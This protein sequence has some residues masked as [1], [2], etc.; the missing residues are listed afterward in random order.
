MSDNARFHNK[1]HRKNHHSLPTPGYP[2][3]GTDPIASQ[4][5]PFYGDF[6]LNGNL[7][8]AGA[9]NTT[10]S[11]LSNISI[12]TPT[13]SSSVIFSPTN[14]LIVQLSGT[15]FA[16]P[17]TPIGNV[18]STYT[19]PVVPTGLTSNIIT[20]LGKTYIVGPLSGND[21]N[22]WN[23]VWTVVS[24]GSANWNGNYT[25]V[26]SNSANWT[27]AYITTTAY[28]AISGSF[29][30]G[31]TVYTYINSTSALNNPTYNAATYAQL[32]AQAF[33]VIAGT[34]AIRPIGGNNIAL[35]TLS[36]I[37]GGCSNQVLSAG[38]SVIGGYCNI[39]SGQYSNVAG[40]QNNISCGFISTVVGG[41]L[42]TSSG[43]Y[44]TVA[45]GKSNCALNYAAVVGGGFG[46]VACNNGTFIG[47][48]IN[49]TAS[50]IYSS[51]GGGSG[52]A[53][54]SSYSSVIGGSF[55]TALNVYS[56][57]AGGICN[58]VSG[59][60]S[61]VNGG[62]SNTVSGIYSNVSNGAKNN[63]TGNFS[64]VVGGTYNTASGCYG[65][66][67]GG[68]CN[69]LVGNSSF[70]LGSN[71]TALSANTVYVNNFCSLGAACNLGGTYSNYLCVSTGVGGS[72]IPN[73]VSQFFA[74]ANS[75]SQ[76]NNQNCNSGSNAS[77]DY[78][79]TADN[80]SDATYYIDMGINSS[81][82]TNTA[83]NIVSAND[84]YLYT[85]GGR[86]A[87]GT[88]SSC[89]LIFHTGGTS[90][91][92][93]R[94]RITP[95]GFVGIGTSAPVATLTVIGGISATGAICGNNNIYSFSNASCAIIPVNGNN[96][97]I[98][99]YALISN[100]VC[101]T[102]NN[103]YTT[104]VNGLSNIGYAG[105][106]IGSG[107]LNTSSGTYSTI[108][109]GA[110][111]RA[112]GNYSA[113]GG[114]SLNCATYNYDSVAGGNCNVA[115]G[116]N[117]HVGGGLC[118]YAY[119]PGSTVVGG[120]CNT[121]SGLYSSIGG[122]CNN[123][124][125]SY[126]SGSN[127][128][129]GSFNVINSPCSII[130]GGSNNCTCQPYTFILGSSLSATQANYTYVNNISST[131]IVATS[132]IYIGNSTAASVSVTGLTSK[133]PIYNATGTLIGYVPI[134]TSIT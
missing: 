126:A 20:Y 63:V 14:T 91:G 39:A 8:V 56:S 37:A 40:G 92:Y 84:G 41:W 129:G 109:G 60:Y 103:T 123:T 76:I 44:S 111:N 101:N 65:A 49:N 66:I 71:I 87:I 120:Y 94:M 133:F 77:T 125:V 80:G 22:T 62:W 89:D 98:G 27:T 26:S 95:Q 73:A 85:Q 50:G 23:S 15:Q 53:A 10:F 115:S 16:I 64:T 132:A 48:G 61:S 81:G 107:C 105:A 24:A 114:G 127:I 43:N 99:T 21:A 31:N 28:A 69:T 134:Y 96:Q 36:N 51:I 72:V 118:N 46:N 74:S 108:P 104:I 116:G 113:V 122:G 35:G 30:G 58:V 119:A 75:Y 13:L 93:E 78:I 54:L 18:G 34:S 112:S 4:A 67:V 90:S 97:A 25:A 52:N 131:G 128:V 45:G 38:S 17:I 55:N 117:S 59:N 102:V 68:Q 47:G 110:C 9:I 79:A 121:S 130:V 42:N 70:I 19:P 29:I 7:N 57:V 12:T 3:S 6:F 33:T 1:L 83:F 106:F 86:L 88:A 100:G 32:S 124:I 82:Y 11:S 2:D 5:E